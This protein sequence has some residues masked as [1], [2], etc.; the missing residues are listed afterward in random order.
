MKNEKA[1]WFSDIM[2][3][4]LKSMLKRL[5][6][7]LGQMYVSSRKILVGFKNQRKFVNLFSSKFKKKNKSTFGSVYRIDCSGCDRSYVGQT[8]RQLLTRI[9]EHERNSRYKTE[10]ISSFAD[11]IISTGHKANFDSPVILA[12][13]R[14]TLK[15]TLFESFYMRDFNTVPGNTHSSELYFY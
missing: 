6:D 3:P 10:G 4:N 13:E 1:I 12:H 5:E 14:N 2:D 7:Y 15:R 11:H 9:K 8:D